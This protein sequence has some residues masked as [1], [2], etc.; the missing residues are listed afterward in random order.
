MASMKQGKTCIRGPLKVTALQVEALQRCA[1]FTL[2][3]CIQNFPSPCT[4][5]FLMTYLL[6]EPHSS[7]SHS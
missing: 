4:K 3:S 6:K 1:A 7:S 2:S 5:P